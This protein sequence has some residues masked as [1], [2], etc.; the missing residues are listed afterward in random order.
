M[1]SED[2]DRNGSTE[3]VIVLTEKTIVPNPPA[4]EDL[5]Q[6]HHMFSRNCLLRFSIR[7]KFSIEI[8]SDDIT[9]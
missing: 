4:S 9:V 3:N 2:V 8:K 7:S 6:A 5:G 1:T